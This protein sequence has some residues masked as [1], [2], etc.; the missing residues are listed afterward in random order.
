MRNFWPAYQPNN[1]RHLIPGGV[2]RPCFG[3]PFVGTTERPIVVMGKQMSQPM[4]REA[5]TRRLMADVISN[6]DWF[7]FL[8]WMDSP[9]GRAVAAEIDSLWELTIRRSK[10]LS[11]FMNR[12]V[13]LGSKPLAWEAE[14]PCVLSIPERTTIL[15]LVWPAECTGEGR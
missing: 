8:E 13:E 11:A 15:P 1:C 14:M 10:E 12:L 7:R 9:D 5:H 2:E 6:C 3:S 4:F